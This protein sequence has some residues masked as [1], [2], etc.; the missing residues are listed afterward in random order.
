M[1]TRLLRWRLPWRPRTRNNP[2]ERQEWTR[3][4]LTDTG[5]VDRTDLTDT[6]RA[7]IAGYNSAIAEHVDIMGRARQSA[8]FTTVSAHRQA[9]ALSGWWAALELLAN[10]VTP[11]D[12]AADRYIGDQRAAW[13]RARE[14]TLWH[15]VGYCTADGVIGEPT[16]PRPEDPS[17]GIVAAGRGYFGYAGIEERLACSAPVDIRLRVDTDG[18]VSIIGPDG[19]DDRTRA[20]MDV[21]RAVR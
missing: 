8:S 19:A 6:D 7:L 14:V 3:D 9:A 12:V 13:F 1:M 21:R 16:V 20:P 18:A 2:Q 11:G 15:A 17:T 10:R 4:V 5:A